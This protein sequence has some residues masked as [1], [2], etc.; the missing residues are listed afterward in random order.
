M[1]T[2]TE[3]F[4]SLKTAVG[5][6]REVT[7][8]EDTF[9]MPKETQAHITPPTRWNE[10]ILSE[11][12]F[13]LSLNT[14]GRFDAELGRALDRLAEHQAREGALCDAACEEAEALLASLQA[15]AKSYR[16]VLAAHAHI[17]MNWM[18]SY[19]ETVAS[20]LATFRTML[21]LMDEYPD[22]HFSQSQAAVYHIVEKYDPDMMEE[23]KRRI[24]QG[25][26]EVTASAWVEADHNMPNTESMLRH[27]EYTRKYLS[28]R[29]GATDFDI[30]FSPDTFG[31]NANL[32]EINRFAG[33]KYFYH[34]RG[35]KEDH[36]LYRYH[37]PS[38]GELLTYREP[39]WYNAAVTPRM[40]IAAP[41]IARRCAGLR[42]SLAVYG[43]GD[44]GGGPTRRDLERA[45]DMMRWPIFPQ[46]T[47][48]S[49]RE[50]FLA[51]ESVRSELPVVAHEVNYFA[52]GCYTTQSRIKRGNRRMEVLLTDAD[53]YGAIA[54]AL[55]GLEPR[56]EALR[57]AWQNVLFTQFHDI[58]TGS[59][60]QDTREHAMG[61]YQQSAAIAN[62]QT[63][64]ALQALCAQID[65]ASLQEA[66]D[67]YRSQS[68]GAGAGYNVELFG[69][70]PCP[71]R[72]SGLRR[73][74]H[75]FNPL[76]ETRKAIVELTAWDWLGDLQRAR[77]TDEAGRE[78]PLQLLDRNLE[79]YWD[80]HYFRF[81]AEVEVPATGYATVVLSQSEA[82]RYPLY[83]QSGE[84]TSATFE[85][86]VLQN[87]RI[88]AVADAG[89]GRLK[90]LRVDGAELI[91]GGSAGFTVVETEA[92]T[93]NAWQIGRHIRH[94]DVSQCVEMQWVTNGPLRQALRVKY[95]VASSTVEATYTLDK[96]ADALRVDTMV[97][98]H[99]IGGQT[100][101]VLDYRV[102]L[103]YRPER[104][105]YDVAAGYTHRAAIENDV[106]ALQYGLAEREGAPCA[107][108]MSDCKYGYR[109]STDRL[110]I[111]LIN[112]STSPDPY[113]ER[114]VHRFVLALGGCAANPALAG[115]MATRFTHGMTYQSGTF[116]KGTLPMKAGLLSLESGEVVVSAVMPDGDSV[117]RIRIYGVGEGAA[118]IRVERPIIG[119][120]RID[121]LGRP[122][123]EPIAVENSVITL[124]VRPNTLAEVRVTLE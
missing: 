2:L 118:R 113:P 19:P 69:G 10:R 68:E 109:G 73:V 26:W 107:I 34:C 86:R 111:T 62:T 79:K 95:R 21:T 57:E 100:I 70:I 28:S 116:H 117:L 71:E 115:Q 8:Y 123:G 38:G 59:C 88:T 106:P 23:I 99:E 17:D 4:I 35:L 98:W 75:V 58:L 65:T 81:L 84:R 83:Y 20:V 25:R 80:H 42:T 15:E 51:A 54:Q 66:S 55:V 97:D 91:A 114:G 63:T 52:P 43:V 29:W 78:I 108:L 24:S 89:T 104:F 87:E 47:F 37:A 60:V 46:M 77:L 9:G 124:S 72:G 74:F 30:D 27:I 7:G 56:P 94:E 120:E 31:H 36:I 40:G 11:L 1:N 64:R 12:E 14:D 67:A 5:G 32:P 33:V 41:D 85:D 92:R 121:A 49:I 103:S 3:R 61:L 102:P 44:H 96:S 82:E 93:S 16:V 45:L 76:A 6:N 13:A 112:S 22:F 50:F 90:S 18:W 105:Q 39:F 122:T 101:P 48:G 110:A 53:A 119:A